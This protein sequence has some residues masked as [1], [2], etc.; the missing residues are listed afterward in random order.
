MCNVQVPDFEYV[1]L[2]IYSGGFTAAEVAEGGKGGTRVALARLQGGSHAE[3]TTVV[4]THANAI[5]LALRTDAFTDQ[6]GFVATYEAVT[7]ACAD[8][9]GCSGNG[10][11]TA[12]GTCACFEGWFGPICSSAHCQMTQAIEG[13]DRGRMRSQ[14]EGLPVPPMANCTWLIV[15]PEADD[16]AASGPITALRMNMLKF[17]FQPADAGVAGEGAPTADG[18]LVCPL[19][20]TGVEQA[21][22]RISGGASNGAPPNGPDCVHLDMRVSRDRA[23]IAPRSCARR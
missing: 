13:D 3:Y 11:C 16:G 2:G 9:A 12:D 20:A 10:E 18:L 5:S 23:E 1:G 4:P 19:D 17:E 22:E 6:G 7:S 21:R 15:P 8:D 14:H